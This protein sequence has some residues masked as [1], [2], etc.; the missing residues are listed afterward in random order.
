MFLQIIGTIHWNIYFHSCIF[1]KQIKQFILI[2][3]LFYFSEQAFC[4]F[5]DIKI[6]SSTPKY[7][8]V[9]GDTNQV[10]NCFPCVK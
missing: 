4:R 10:S 5:G 1:A 3:L 2:I 9:A 6:V 8:L 7:Y